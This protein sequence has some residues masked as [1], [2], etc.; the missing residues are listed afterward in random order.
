MVWNTPQ[1]AFSLM[2]WCQS[3]ASQHTAAIAEPQLRHCQTLGIQASCIAGSPQLFRMRSRSVFSIESVQ[4]LFSMWYSH[5]YDFV[6][7]SS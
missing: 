2:T 3:P 6:T 5:T 7:L 4:V 1:F